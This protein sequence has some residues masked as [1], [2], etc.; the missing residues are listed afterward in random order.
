[1]Q[2]LGID[3]ELNLVDYL[4]SH[5]YPIESIV[6]EW[7]PKEHQRVDLAIVDPVTKTPAAIFEVKSKTAAGSI[8]RGIQ[9]ITQYYRAI[10]DS[11]LLGYLVV[12]SGKS[13]LEFYLVDEKGGASKIKKIPSYALLINSAVKKE[14]RKIKQESAHE[15]DKFHVTAWTLAVLL[16]IVLILDQVRVST[17]DTNRLLVMGLIS[18][19]FIAPFVARI[20]V[21]GIE[22]DNLNSDKKTQT[23]I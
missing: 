6:M 18:T 8:E 23:K 22:I 14:W 16:L 20:R 12:S 21:F 1:M 15:I 7:E 10:G 13:K 17:L 4:I 3:Q 5:G 19:L 11:H 9:Q 2:S